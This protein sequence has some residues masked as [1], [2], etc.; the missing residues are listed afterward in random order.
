[1]NRKEGLKKWLLALSAMVGLA[2]SSTSSAYSCTGTIDWVS[3]NPAGVITVSSQSSGMATFYVCQ[4][5]QAQDGVPPEVCSSMLATLL[6]AKATGAQV[7]WSFDDSSNT[8][9]RASYN[10]GNWY[11]LGGS[12]LSWYYGPQIQ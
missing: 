12:P 6:T 1:M 3:L 10:G 4:I 2:A 7:I 11:W 8:C 9:N 5:G